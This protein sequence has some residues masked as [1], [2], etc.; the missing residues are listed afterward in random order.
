MCQVQDFAQHATFA[1]T[2]QQLAEQLV[3]ALGH[4]LAGGGSVSWQKGW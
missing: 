2:E 1:Q 3:A 4:S